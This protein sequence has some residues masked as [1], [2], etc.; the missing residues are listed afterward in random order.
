MN[1]RNLNIGDRVVIC[2]SRAFS[3]TPTRYSV[4]T[5]T[6]K[7][8]RTV[9]CSNGYVYTASGARL[10]TAGSYSVSDNILAK[11]GTLN[12]NNE[13]VDEAWVARMN[14]EADESMLRLTMIRDIQ[15]WA[16]ARKLRDAPMG[17]I[18]EVHALLRRIAG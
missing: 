8:S 6:A 4:A 2:V 14:G 11:V 16:T 13:M 3:K 18:A 17:D 7:T 10:G 15:A 5:V 1:I 12:F 9:R